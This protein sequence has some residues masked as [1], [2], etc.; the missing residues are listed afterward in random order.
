[1][2]KKITCI[3]NAC[4]D[5]IAN[6]PVEFLKKNHIEKS[7]CTHLGMQEHLL[8]IKSQLPS[9]KMIPGGAG[10]NVSHTLSALGAN[11]SFITNIAHDKEGLAFK[12]NL[13]D[14]EVETHAYIIEEHEIS[15]PQVLCFITP[16]GDRSFASYNG[17]ALSFCKDHIPHSTISHTD[18]L[19][20]DGYTFCSAFTEDA[21]KES[22]NKVHTQ[23]GISCLNVGDRS[24]I[25]LNN[26]AIRNILD[27][28]DGF[29]CNKPEAC[30]LYGE[31]KTIQQIAKIMAG[32]FHF[33]AITD[34]SNGAYIILNEKIL[35]QPAGDTSHIQ[36]IDSIGA[37]DHFSAGIL[38]GVSQNLPLE[39]IG[40]LA[41]LCAI[42]CLSHAGGRPLGGK[43]SLK[44]LVEQSKN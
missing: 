43:E 4:T 28:C 18:I 41:N 14:A 36:A 11:T 15:S 39:Q 31:D 40:K 17:S 1:M 9:C 10:A 32:K 35:Y 2:A 25:E 44:S 7:Y 30:A 38:Y 42:D 5:I 22:I 21:F 16:D 6:V 33:G 26:T 24:L 37:G 12:K 19:Y 13:E 8:S 23:N 34:G 3:G 29:I 20:L 27:Q